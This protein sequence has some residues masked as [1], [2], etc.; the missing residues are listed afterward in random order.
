MSLISF[1]RACAI[2]SIRVRETM[3]SGGM[4][5]AGGV[6]GG[7]PASGVGTCAGS[8]V[9][10]GGGVPFSGAAPFFFS[11]FAPA[12]APPIKAVSAS[13][14]GATSLNDLLTPSGVHCACS[15]SI[16]LPSS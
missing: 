11:S 5:S 1:S 8:P 16:G 6:A 2:R 12:P 15:A 14:C 7:V 13:V 9:A 3:R 4:L 10:S